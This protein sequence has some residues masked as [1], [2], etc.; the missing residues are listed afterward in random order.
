MKLRTLILLIKLF[1]ASHLTV[2]EMDDWFNQYQLNLENDLQLS[3]TINELN[4]SDLIILLSF[5]FT[6][7]SSYIYY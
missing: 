5:G 4:M 7:G 2:E 6:F 3:Y 1:L